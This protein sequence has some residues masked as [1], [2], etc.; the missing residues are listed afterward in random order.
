[1]SADDR[2]LQQRIAW[3]KERVQRLIAEQEARLAS[4]RLAA[5][6]RRGDCIRDLSRALGKLQRLRQELAALEEGRLPGRP[7]EVK[8]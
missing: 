5:Y 1:M 4:I 2:R 6:L 7:R 3:R 8:P